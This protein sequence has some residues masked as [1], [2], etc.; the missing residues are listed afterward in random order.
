MTRCQNITHWRFER[1]GDISGQSLPVFRL[2]SLQFSCFAEDLGE[3]VCEA[4][5]GCALFAVLEGAT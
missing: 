4:I 3:A 5:E 1:I 2:G